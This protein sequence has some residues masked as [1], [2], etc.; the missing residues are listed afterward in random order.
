M[1]TPIALTIACRSPWDKHR[2]WNVASMAT[3]P[4]VDPPTAVW[5][6]LC[7][8]PTAPSSSDALVK[9][10]SDWAGVASA[11]SFGTAPPA[12]ASCRGGACEAGPAGTPAGE[13]SRDRDSS[14]ISSFKA[15]VREIHAATSGGRC[16]TTCWVDLW[17]HKIWPPVGR[18][19]RIASGEAATGATTTGA[20]SCNAALAHAAI[21]GV[22]APPGGAPSGAADASAVARAG[23]GTGGAG[24]VPG[25][26]HRL[27]PVRLFWKNKAPDGA[28]R[29]SHPAGSGGGDK[30]GGPGDFASG[31]GCRL[32]GEFAATGGGGG[33]GG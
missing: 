21:G 31:A 27:S 7:Q 5:S 1:W 30:S 8:A 18:S 2:V 19:E 32:T 25:W 13:R 22:A 9:R 12:A 15:A 23:A 6:L 16:I 4:S 33:G 11:A 24:P 28:R 14:L 3:R 26:S 20:V 10:A 17:N 29:D